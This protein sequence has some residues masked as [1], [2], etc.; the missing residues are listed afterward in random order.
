MTYNEAYQEWYQYKRRMVKETTLAAYALSQRT[1]LKPA[2]GDMDVQTILRK[3]VQAFVYRKL[4]GGLSVKSVRDMLIVLKMVIRY[5][6]C[7]SC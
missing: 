6:T 2:F 4:D 7:S 5:A 1:H 3:D